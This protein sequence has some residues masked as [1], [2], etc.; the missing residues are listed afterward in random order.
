MVQ[1]WSSRII[2]LHGLQGATQLDHNK[3]VSVYVSTSTSYDFNAVTSC[4]EIVTKM[5]FY[6]SSHK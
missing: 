2:L 4:V 6:V 5:C 3:D 1:L